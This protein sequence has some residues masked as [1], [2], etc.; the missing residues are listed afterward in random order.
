MNCF[1]VFTEIKSYLLENVPGIAA[2]AVSVLSL[3]ISWLAYKRDDPRLVFAVYAAEQVGAGPKTTGLA[4]SIYNIGKVSVKIESI[5]GKSSFFRCK[6]IVFKILKGFTPKK[7]VPTEFLVSSIKIDAYLRPAG[8]PVSLP[9]GERITFVIGDPDG[10]TLGKNI[11]E[12]ASALFLSDAVGNR[13][14]LKHDRFV[15]LKKDYKKK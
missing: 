5:G 10:T 7:L 15:K 9:P 6:S 2:F 4:I 13:F 8:R 14:Y 12:K 11:T 3:W 1:S